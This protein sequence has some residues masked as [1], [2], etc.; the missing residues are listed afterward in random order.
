[1]VSEVT[2]EKVPSKG[3]EVDKVEDTNK[4]AEQQPDMEVIKRE[5]EDLKNKLADKS[6]KLDDIHTKYQMLKKEKEKVTQQRADEAKTKDDFLKELEELRSYKSTRETKDEEDFGSWVGTLTPPIRQYVEKLQSAGVK[7]RNVLRSLVS[8]NI[9]SGFFANKQVT[10][11]DVTPPA[12]NQQQQK[13]TTQALPSSVR[14]GL[15]KMVS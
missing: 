1:M 9:Q 15:S 5:N 11:V 6:V 2:T 4:A 8:E 14:Q 10:K 13:Q 7:D 3:A 12:K